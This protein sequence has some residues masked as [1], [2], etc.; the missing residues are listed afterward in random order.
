MAGSPYT[1]LSRPPMREAA[2]SRALVTPEGLWTE[3]RVVTVTGSTNADVAEAARAGAA[4]GLVVV[5][6]SQTAGRGRLGRRWLAPPRAGLAVSA[7]LRPAVPARHLGWLGLAAGVALAEAVARI[8]VVDTVLKWPNDLLV[9]PAT[10]TDARY[11]KCGGVLA[12]TVANDA[13]GGGTAG[14]AVVVGFGLNVSQHADELP[15][16]LDPAAFPP[17]AL[18]LADATCT[19]RDPLLRGVLRALADWYGRWRDAGGDADAC[20]LLAAYRRLC[21]TIGTDVTVTVPGGETVPGRASDVDADGRLMVETAYG[22]RD[23]A[24]GDVTHVR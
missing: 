2:L 16:P 15:E 6:E 18:S 14:P 13:G 8:A 20:G 7:L 22:R 12:E 1:D 9:R 4:E 5:A 24:A 19:D 21:L 23:L 17:T 3:L 11:G 10:A